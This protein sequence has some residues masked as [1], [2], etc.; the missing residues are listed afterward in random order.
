MRRRIARRAFQNRRRFL[1]GFRVAAGLLGFACP[2]FGLG[3]LPKGFTFR[4][5]ERLL[6]LCLPGL[7]QPRPKVTEDPALA[8]DEELAPSGVIAS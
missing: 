7:G 3:T 8:I 4:R 6:A 5:G 2:A 1:A